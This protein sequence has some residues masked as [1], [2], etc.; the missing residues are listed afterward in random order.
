[1]GWREMLNAISVSVQTVAALFVVDTFADQ[2]VFG[3]VVPW[4]GCHPRMA[5]HPIVG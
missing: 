1:M 5:I 3:H 2:G 4:I